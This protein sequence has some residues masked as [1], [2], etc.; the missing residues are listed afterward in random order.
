[1]DLIISTALKGILIGVL[2]SAPMGPIGV[3]CIQRTLS[4]SRYSGFLSGLGVARADTMLAIIS[5]FFYALLKGQIEQYKDIISIFGGVFVVIV[6]V[7]IFFKKPA[8]QV[9]RKANRQDRYTLF[10]P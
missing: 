4:K 3:L 1:M 2:V 10:P 9:R 8:P 6:G 5:Y 7:A